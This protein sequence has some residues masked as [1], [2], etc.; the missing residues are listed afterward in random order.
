[1]YAISRLYKVSVKEIVDL[2]PY[3][4]KNN[5]DVDDVLLIPNGEAFTQS[6]DREKTVERSATT[7]N[8]GRNEQGSR[9]GKVILPSETSANTKGYRVESTPVKKGKIISFPIPKIPNT[10]TAQSTFVGDTPPTHVI[11][12]GETLSSIARYYKL[13]LNKLRKINHMGERDGLN[14]N[15]LI[16]L[17]NM[18][19]HSR[20][21]MLAEHDQKLEY[22]RNPRAREEAMV[23]M[24]DYSKMKPILHTTQK[25]ETLYSLSKTYNHSVS[26]LKKWNNMDGDELKK[27]QELIIGWMVPGNDMSLTGTVT[28]EGIA[29][30][31]N[32]ER[33]ANERAIFDQMKKFENKFRAQ[34]ANSYNSELKTGNCVG[35]YM[36][37]NDND[38]Q[39]L[40]CL[41]RTIPPMT[42]VHLTNPMNGKSIYVKVISDLP[43]TSD[44]ANADIKLTQAAVKALGILDRKFQIEYSYFIE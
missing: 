37:G 21:T 40:F 23:D 38:E 6:M 18:H 42:I 8:A 20:Q 39:N 19:S 4:S 9:A 11:Q 32:A 41:S 31:V 28:G 7:Q 33:I 16:F 3:I 27:D 13:D 10:A 22:E 25:G 17:R 26:S 36:R 35:T 15:E 29:R 34:V 5:I 2:N 24:V 44:N 30:R 14:A 12:S 43:E 1:M